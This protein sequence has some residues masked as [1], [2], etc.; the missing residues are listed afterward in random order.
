MSFTTARKAKPKDRWDCHQHR[1]EL[2]VSDAAT[3][4]HHE[5]GQLCYYELHWDCIAWHPIRF[6]DRRAAYEW[7]E[8]GCIAD[9][10]EGL[11]TLHVCFSLKTFERRLSFAEEMELL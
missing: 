7:I 6:K 4:Y 2:H 8:S 10:Q 1:D 11:G 9:I 3:V 5:R